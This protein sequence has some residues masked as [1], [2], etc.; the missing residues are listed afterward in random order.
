MAV[1]AITREMRTGGKEVASNVAERL[2]L[3]IVHNELVEHDIAEDSGLEEAVVHRV[4]E[5]EASILERWRTNSTRLSRSTAQEIFSLAANGD[6]L[7]RGW[8]ATHL[9]RNIPHVVCVHLCAPIEARAK[10]VMQQLKISEETIA[11][12]EIQRND[13]AHTAAMRRIFDIDWT[14]VTRYSAILNT[15]R[16]SIDE[17]AQFIVSLAESSAFEETDESKNALNDALIRARVLSALENLY[18]S[19]SNG[20]NVDASQGRVTISGSLIGRAAMDDAIQV[21]S[22]V[23]GVT[24][25]K[26]DLVYAH[27]EA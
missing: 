8:G 22:E 27:I 23:D 2:G 12:R 11:Q 26:S 18:V 25:V 20:L 4:L 19:A 15:S 10:R 9:L 13:G 5:G 24:S 17:C 7:I 14:D 6:V 16:I 21:A 1:I 3:S